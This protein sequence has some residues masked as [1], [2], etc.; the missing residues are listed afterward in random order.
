MPGK[1]PIKLVAPI[2]DWKDYFAQNLC[3]VRLDP[4]STNGLVK[5]SA[6]DT[7]Q[8]RGVDRQRFIRKLGQ[9]CEITMAEQRSQR[10]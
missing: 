9:V 5:V 2:T 3:H 6:A 4:D 7:L 10:I 1:L 8:L